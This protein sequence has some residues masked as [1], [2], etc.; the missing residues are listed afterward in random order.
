[1]DAV[2]AFMWKSRSFPSP[3]D[4]KGWKQAHWKYEKTSKK[5]NRKVLECYQPIIEKCEMGG[6][7]VIDIKPQNW[8]DNGKVL[9]YTHGGA[10]TLLSSESTIYIAAPVAD[11]TGLRVVS[12]DFTTAPFA[13]WEVITDQ[14]IAVIRALAEEGYGLNSIGLYGDSSGG[15][16]AAG[17]VLKMRDRGYGMPGAVVLWSPWPDVTDTYIIPKNE[18]SKY[19][20]PVSAYVAICKPSVNAYADPKDHKHPYVSPAYG[21]YQEGFSPTLIQ[22]GTD[23]ILFDNCLRYYQTLDN[24]GQ[25]VKFEPYE[26]MW[27]SFQTRWNLPESKLARKKMTEFLQERLEY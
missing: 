23:E 5:K 20:E 9:V 13:Q 12:V 27:H 4:I 21:N 17:S 26:G 14:V 11:T 3:K 19:V 24:A 1:M 10:Y 2:A 18:R 25:V 22:V 15:S 8:Q 7:P 16:L 6:V